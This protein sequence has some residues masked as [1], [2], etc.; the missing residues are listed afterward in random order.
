MKI[1][2][3]GAGPAG[4]FLAALMKAADPG[5][6]ITVLER[7]PP[8]ATFGFG[9]VFS[10]TTLRG[11]AAADPTL[12]AR[13]AEIGVHWS[14][15]EVRHR[16]ERVRAGGNGFA[17]VSRKALLALLEERAVELGVRVEHGVQVT[18]PAALLGENDLVV[19]CD[20]LGSTVR[21]AFAE[22]LQP[23]VEVGLA[24]Y[25]WFATPQPF[26]ALTFVFAENEHGWFGAHAYP[27]ASGMSTFIV[28]TD[29]QTWR[30]AGLEAA[31]APASPGESDAFAMAYVADTFRETLGR[32]PLVGNASRWGAFRTVRNASWHHENLVILGDTAHTAHFS[33]GSGT[34]MAMEDALALAGVLT[35]EGLHPGALAA[36]EAER[37]PQVERIQD[38]AHPSLGWWERFARWTPLAPPQL[39]YH[40]LTRS[41]RVGHE[42]LRVRDRRLATQ[43][44]AAFAAAHPG[45][46]PRHGPLSAPLRIGPV[47]LPNRVGA[48]VSVAPG[49]ALDSVE[50]ACAVAGPAWSGA[51][52]VC[53]DGDGL[54]QEQHAEAWPR[55]R[56]L[57]AQRSAACVLVRI[58]GDLPDRELAAVAR[59][60]AGSGVEFVELT[61]RRLGE[62]AGAR[63]IAA[64]REAGGP[65]LVTLELTLPDRPLAAYEQEAVDFARVCR[66]AGVA[67]LSLR[68]PPGPASPVVLADRLGAADAIRHEAGLPVFLL[69]GL[70]TREAL[71]TAVLAGRAD[72]G[73]GEPTLLSGAWGAGR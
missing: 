70:R 55:L 30:R 46:D 57:V 23:S 3:V 2:C 13:L 62:Q 35:R 59:T 68:L 21:T 14:D 38:A 58:P 53:V 47:T 19:G 69:G 37:R 15:I 4:L 50:A 22:H 65:A 33:V 29:E 51:G 56:A 11:L 67:A 72:L 25:I 54:L 31:P 12:D 20:G 40:F 26:D 66:A 60:S 48:C 16:G 63:E 44:E 52:L 64:L 41:Q 18:D 6:D 71:V 61:G 28:E 36:Y 7:D 24:K 43:V 8:G 5:H 1:T 42:N 34:K 17:A 10:D 32:H 45:T 73:C 9:V 39:A 49:L 27:F